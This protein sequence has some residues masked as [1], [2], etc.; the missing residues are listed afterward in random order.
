MSKKFK[1]DFTLTTETDDQGHTR[2]VSTYIGSVFDLEINQASL[3]RLK[4]LATFLYVGGFAS[5]VA[6]GFLQH[7][8]SYQWF[9]SIPYALAF[10]PIGLL[11]FA[12]VRLPK[13]TQN[14]RRYQTEASFT[15]GC[16][17]AI[18][19]LGLIWLSAVGLALFV[20]LNG[21]SL[22]ARPDYLYL[23]LEI[24]SSIMFLLLFTQLNRVKIKKCVA[25][26]AQ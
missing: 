18:F 1:D 7:S 10:L 11:G 13:E 12:L 2:Q 9:V 19:A 26:S 23:F 20:L 17:M 24:F 6:A 3:N 4:V 5:H 15:R 8:A 25:Y 22:T 14:L 16:T 21:G